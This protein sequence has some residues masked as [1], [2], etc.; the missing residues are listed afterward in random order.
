MALSESPMYLQLLRIEQ[1]IDAAYVRKQVE[2]QETLDNKA[3]VCCSH[4]SLAVDEHCTLNC[5]TRAA[6]PRYLPF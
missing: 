1:A 5:W 4:L 6:I 2:L 3:R